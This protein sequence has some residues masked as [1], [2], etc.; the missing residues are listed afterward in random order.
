MK[1]LP[2]RVAYSDAPSAPR[3]IAYLHDANVFGGM[4]VLQL[5]MLKHIDPYRYQAHVV[6]PGYDDRDRSSPCEFIELLHE[7]GVPV[8][9]PPHP[10]YAPLRSAIRDIRNIAALL[11]REQIDLVHIQTRHPEAARKATFA[12]WL[13]RMKAIVRTEHLPP[14][15]HMRWQ[16]RYTIVPF[17]WMTDRIIAD[18][19]TNR[20]EQIR[21]LGRPTWKVVCSYCGIDT[22]QFNPD[23]DVAQAKRRIGLNPNLPVVGAIGR[24]HVQKGMTYLIDAMPEVLRE[25]GPVQFLLIGD[26]P[27]MGELRAQVERLGMGAYIHF[28]G[29]QTKYVPYM[30]AIDIGVM[31]SLWEGFSISMQEY[32]ALGKPMIVTNHG[33]FLE[34][35]THEQHGLIVATRDSAGLSASILR[36]L[37]D[38]ALARQLGQAALA[39][40]R[41]EFSVQQHMRDLMSLY[42]TLLHT[43]ATLRT[44]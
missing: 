12:A 34:A 44:T 41:S 17:D 23:H 26:G 33:S 1:D 6:I 10:G 22:S 38:P 42:D 3:R 2:Q 11:R 20:D 15:H 32:M 40:V 39:R 18:S 13:A 8:L 16:T 7:A 14:S 24:L 9:K 37:R 19:N 31:P 25:Y 28:A 21:L 30:E 36:L 29:F 35:L 5:N 43:N 4:E 27:L